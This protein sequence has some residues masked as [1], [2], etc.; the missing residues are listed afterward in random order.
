MSDRKTEYDNLFDWVMEFL[1]GEYTDLEF[2]VNNE[3]E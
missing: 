3:Y 1:R 2:I